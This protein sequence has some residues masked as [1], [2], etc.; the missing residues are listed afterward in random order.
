MVRR[1]VVRAAWIAAA[2]LAV[3][4]GCS[5]KD[6]LAPPP[7]ADSTAIESPTAVVQRF[8]DAWVRRDTTAL[9]ATLDPVFSYATG[10]VDRN[11]ELFY[12]FGPLRDTTLMAAA[13]LFRLGGVGHP[14][15]TTIDLTL[16]SLDVSP[17]SQ[18][19]VHRCDVDIL[20]VRVTVR[21][22]ADTLYLGG[23]T[24]LR[25]VRS[26]IVVPAPPAEVRWRVRVWADI[27][28]SEEVPPGTA[29]LQARR[30][31][32]QIV[33]ASRTAMPA[34][35][36]RPASIGSAECDSLLRRTWG[37]ALRRYLE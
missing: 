20:S 16:D 6:V 19:P 33:R 3:V 28:M 17:D 36:G 14:P 11:G 13:R 26:D 21:T 7:A 2:I 10:C 37:Y 8:R 29:R 12:G 24:G 23:F 35:S 18:D 32:Q 4:V 15:A 30:G 9:A 1:R 5:K 31:F 25:L 27:V 34:S 22:P